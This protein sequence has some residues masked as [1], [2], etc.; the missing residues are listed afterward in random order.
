MASAWEGLQA[1]VLGTSLQVD[2]Y[3]VPYPTNEQM[4]V[5]MQGK[6]LTLARELLG[7]KWADWKAKNR[8]KKD[9]ERFCDELFAAMGLDRDMVYRLLAILTND[10]Y[11]RA[12]EAD[13]A[14]VGVS[15]G[16]FAQ[17]LMSFRHLAVLVDQASSESRLTKAIAGPVADWTMDQYMQADML[18]MMN[19]QLTVLHYI[20]AV[21]GYS[22]SVKAPKP[23]YERPVKPEK[24]KPV[25]TD[26]KSAA[27]FFNSLGSV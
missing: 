26:T 21:G 7:K 20:L 14:D 13:L 27:A 16:A 15:L 18:D 11:F 6:E 10:K 22:K 12:L 8:S 2:G 5:L 9:V 3:K 17:G 19:F 1:E 24:P 25:F 23:I 4:L